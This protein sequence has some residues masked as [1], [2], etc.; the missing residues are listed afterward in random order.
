M[1]NK[2]RSKHIYLDKCICAT[3]DVYLQKYITTNTIVMKKRFLYTKFIFPST[4]IY[5]ICDEIS[6]KFSTGKCGRAINVL[7]SKCNSICRRYNNMES[8]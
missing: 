6:M 7:K 5:K 8:N 3:S 1:K 2:L 4:D